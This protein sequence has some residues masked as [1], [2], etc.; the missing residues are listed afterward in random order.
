M[1]RLYV[2]MA[3]WGPHSQSLPPAMILAPARDD[4]PVLDL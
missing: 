4:V 3:I 2:S 1:H